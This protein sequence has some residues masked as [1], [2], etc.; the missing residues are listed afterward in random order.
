MP[1]KH[2]FRHND[3]VFGMNMDDLLR[4]YCSVGGHIENVPYFYTFPLNEGSSGR[5]WTSID[6]C[7]HLA[8]MTAS[9]MAFSLKWPSFQIF[10][11]V[12]LEISRMNEMPFEIYILNFYKVGM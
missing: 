12:H 11:P 7:T 5:A 8:W 10:V 2:R 9:N 4:I 6:Q 3:H 1:P